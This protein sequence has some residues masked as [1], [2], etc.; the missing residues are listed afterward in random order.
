MFETAFAQ[1]PEA[2]LS[3]QTG[4]TAAIGGYEVYDL[5][6]TGIAWALII[7]AFLSVIFIFVGGISFILSGGQEDKVKNAVST[8]RYAIIGLVT[9]ILA[10]TVVALVGRVFGV[11]L[12]FIKFQEI[13]NTANEIIAN[14][15]SESSPNTL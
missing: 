10:V 2:G 15:N 4:N 9:T 3:T 6:H 14:F 12:V 8:I 5:I 1:A 13:L 11:D 7:A